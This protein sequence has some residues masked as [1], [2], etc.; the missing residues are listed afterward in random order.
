MQSL[1]NETESETTRLLHT[2]GW[3]W[4]GYL[5]TL[6]VID[7]LMYRS[8]LVS[9]PYYIVN[10]LVALVFLGM[11]YWNGLRRFL[12][13]FYLPLML[14]I[15]AAL[16]L[17]ISH[18]L[19]N[20]AFHGSMS[21]PEGMALRQM[22]V[23]FVALVITAWQ[24][25]LAGVITFT[26]GTALLELL[27]VDIVAPLVSFVSQPPQ[28]PQPFGPVPFQSIDVFLFLNLVRTVSFLVVG[29]FLS[30]LITRLRA[31]QKSLADANA[32]L[33]H[34]AST[35]ESLTLSRER[36]RLAHELHDTLAHSLTAISVQLE[37]VKAYWSV[38]RKRSH[39]LLEQSLAS[40]R[41]GLEETRRALRA[42]RAT[43]LEEL[44]LG[45]ALRNLA[46]SIA[47][48]AGLELELA[49]PEQIPSLSPVVEQCIYRIVQEA[50][51][52]IV[53]HAGATHVRLSLEQSG[54]TLMLSIHDDG[55]GFDPESDS[56]Q[57]H[58][59]LLGMRERAEM[60]GGDFQV[61]STPGQ[62]TTVS[63]SI[64]AE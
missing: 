12:K 37:A 8:I 62:G 23:L 21:N 14:V 49:L 25:R 26:G 56:G 5:A 43:P 50:F 54:Q 36:N 29:A 7:Q 16:P 42:L 47:E 41:S 1:R 2:A 35:L 3:L 63:L 31:Q 40:T 39:N 19:T 9:L 59:G 10:G 27:M 45:L 17:V 61:H 30:Q 22:P 28:P 6:L 44:G 55:A 53:S 58:F 60:A 46:T 24:Y 51:Q 4:L 32:R 57:D 34:Y 13:G 38:D 33:T 48:R 18:L 20:N 11:A 64:G 52:N 15:M